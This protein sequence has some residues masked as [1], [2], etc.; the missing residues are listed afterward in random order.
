MFLTTYQVMSP[1]YKS[2]FFLS[3][4]DML[5]LVEEKGQSYASGFRSVKNSSGEIGRIFQG[6]AQR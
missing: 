3:T 5:N 2:K 4:Y 6:L 1:Q